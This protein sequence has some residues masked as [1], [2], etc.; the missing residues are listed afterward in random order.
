VCDG[1]DFP[2][3]VQR[4]ASASQAESDFSFPCIWGYGSTPSRFGPSYTHTTRKARGQTSPVPMEIEQRTSRMQ[5][6]D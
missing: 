5:T 4:L 6:N 2:Y 3:A 1:K